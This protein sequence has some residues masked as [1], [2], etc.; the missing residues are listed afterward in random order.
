MSL[1]QTQTSTSTPT[2]T[3]TMDSTISRNTSP[4]STENSIQRHQSESNQHHHPPTTKD[5]SDLEKD[6]GNSRTDN[7]VEQDGTI[8]VDWEENGEYFQKTNPLS[9]WVELNQRVQS[10]SAIGKRWDQISLF[11]SCKQSQ[12]IQ[13]GP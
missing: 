6:G 5:S 13:F 10:N 9:L 2:P 8:W 11:N 1:P 12:K 4:N 3:P 7:Q